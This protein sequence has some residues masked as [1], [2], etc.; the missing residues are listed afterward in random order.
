MSG[1]LPPTFTGNTLWYTD[2]TATNLAGT[3]WL[4]SGC[5][6]SNLTIN[7]TGTTGIR[8]AGLRSNTTPTLTGN[9]KDLLANLY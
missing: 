5:T 9:V 2:V 4:L 6:L 7:A 8:I 3:R 1:V